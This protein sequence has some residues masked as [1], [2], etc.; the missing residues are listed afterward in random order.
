MSM[1]FTR[2]TDDTQRENEMIELP[3]LNTFSHDRRIRQSYLQRMK[4]IIGTESTMYEMKEDSTEKD[5]SSH[6][7]DDIKE[8]QK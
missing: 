1:Q 4:E 6:D 7:V 5:L 8:Q 3:I 2:V